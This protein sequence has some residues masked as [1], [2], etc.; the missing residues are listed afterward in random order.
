VVR[1]ATIVPAAADATGA[2]DDVCVAAE[3]AL[4]ALKR[5]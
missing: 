2:I 4:R 1:L 5:R 3:R